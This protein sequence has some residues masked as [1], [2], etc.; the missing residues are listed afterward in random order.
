[1]LY[2]IDKNNFEGCIMASMKDDIRTDHSRLTLK[3]FREMKNNP[4]LITVTVEEFELMRDKYIQ[5]VITSLREITEDDFYTVFKEQRL[6]TGTLDKGYTCFFFGESY[7]WNIYDCY[8]EVSGRYFT[9]KKQTGITRKEI[10]TEVRQLNKPEKPGKKVVVL[11][12]NSTPEN[13]DLYSY[14]EKYDIKDIDELFD[15]DTCKIRIRGY[16][17]PFICI[18]SDSIIFIVYSDVEYDIERKE[19]ETILFLFFSDGFEE[20]FTKKYSI[21]SDYTEGCI[22]FK[23]WGQSTFAIWQYNGEIPQ[24][25]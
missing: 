2:I 10:E 4:D 7:G 9:G 25:K 19:L 11:E 3:E 1:M 13:I 21:W 8:C 24:Q 6:R 18:K 12:Y 22:A 15:R 14:L 17:Y 20:H 16:D 5:T 23:E